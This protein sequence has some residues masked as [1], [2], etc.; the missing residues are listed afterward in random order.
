MTQQ[1]P[2]YAIVGLGKT[3]LSVARYLAKKNLDFVM[4]DT[5]ANPPLLKEFLA[6]FPHAPIALDGLF[7]QKLNAAKEIILSPGL[8]S[9][10]PELQEAQKKGV[11][12]IGDIELFARDCAGTIIAITGSNGKSTVTTLVGL[13]LAQAGFSVQVGGNLGEPAL[14]LL[15]APKADF[16]VLELSSFQLETT[17]SLRNHIACIL[18]ITADHMDRYATL[19]DYIQAKQRIYQNC[20]NA[21]YTL[22]DQHTVPQTANIQ[23]NFRF[24]LQTPESNNDYGIRAQDQKNYLS[25][26]VQLLLNVDELKIKGQHNWLNALAALAIYQAA[27]KC[28]EFGPAIQALKEF[29]GLAHRCEWVAEQNQIMW[30]NDSKGT[31][32]GATQAALAG[33][34]QAISGKI[35]WIAGGQGKGADFSAL[36]PTVFRFV[37]H[38]ILIGQDATRIA[39]ILEQKCSY[40]FAE[41][42]TQAVSTA[43]QY[44]KPNDCVLL[45]PACASFDQFK[46]FIDR[47]EQF[48]LAVKELAK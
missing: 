30:I 35:I 46:D 36:A 34:G 16:Y 19:N 20:R 37:R 22:D 48:K 18:N 45:S 29:P 1:N 4:M 3:G 5:R 6:A 24:S 12:I 42:I 14:D 9:Q 33:L 26:G 8:S 47:G 2:Y 32:V 11:P 21:I 28:A 17:F 10:L 39:N 13:M 23:E 40:Q 38:A 27:T 7:A 41:N 15:Q 44:A 25:C 31:N 43:L